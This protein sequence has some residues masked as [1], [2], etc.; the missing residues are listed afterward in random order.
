MSRISV[1]AITKFG[2][3]VAISLKFGQM[4][5]IEFGQEFLSKIMSKSNALKSKILSTLQQESF[6][7]LKEFSKIDRNETKIKEMLQLLVD[8]RQVQKEK[9]GAGQYYSISSLKQEYM[10][11]S[12]EVEEMRGK[13]GELKIMAQQVVLEFEQE[14]GKLPI[15][16]QNIGPSLDQCVNIGTEQ[17]SGQE[18]VVPN[19]QDDGQDQKVQDDEMLDKNNH[20]ELTTE[21]T[22]LLSKLSSILAILTEKASIYN[23]QSKPIVKLPSRTSVITSIK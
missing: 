2:Q 6:C 5:A 23:V 9:I 13:L 17:E 10:M 18:N 7:H 21:I 16:E 20:Q 1:I 11:K 4:V 8:D 19:V 15:I 22:L 14:Y 12:S 3:M